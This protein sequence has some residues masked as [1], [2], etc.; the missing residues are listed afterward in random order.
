MSLANRLSEVTPSRGNHGCITCKYVEDLNLKDR[1]AFD[2][3]IAEGLSL[4]QLWDI[5]SSDP[6]H[7]LLVSVTGLRHHV[8]HHKPHES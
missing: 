6:E 5:A 3:W 8:K 2:Q 1:L 7:P 4:V